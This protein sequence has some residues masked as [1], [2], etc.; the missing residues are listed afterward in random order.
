[1]TIYCFDLSQESTYPSLRKKSDHNVALEAS[2]P[3]ITPPMRFGR[4]ESTPSHKQ[5]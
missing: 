5:Y 1:M 2:M 3:T 4:K